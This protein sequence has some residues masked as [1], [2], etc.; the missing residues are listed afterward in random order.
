[1]TSMTGCCNLKRDLNCIGTGLNEDV[2]IRFTAL[3]DLP[4]R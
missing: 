2:M 1:M 3:V 4:D